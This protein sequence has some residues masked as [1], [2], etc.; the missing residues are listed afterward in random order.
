MP[1]VERVSHGARVR[2]AYPHIGAEH[3]EVAVVVVSDTV[4]QP[5]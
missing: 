1:A 2:R 3:E 5:G 4:I